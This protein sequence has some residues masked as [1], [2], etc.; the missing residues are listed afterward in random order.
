[1]ERKDLLKANGQIFKIQGMALNEKASRKLK[2][3]L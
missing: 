3:S 2:L 1:M